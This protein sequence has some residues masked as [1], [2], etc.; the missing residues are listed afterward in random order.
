ME[1]HAE[2]HDVEDVQATLRQESAATLHG[3]AGVDV[4]RPERMRLK[5]GESIF[6][7]N[8]LKKLRD[9]LEGK[10]VI[11]IDQDGV[12]VPY[13]REDDEK[14]V[15]YPEAVDAVRELKALGYTLIYWTSGKHENSEIEEFLKRTEIDDLFSVVISRENFY[16]KRYEDK[17]TILCSIASTP[18]LSEEARAFLIKR[19]EKY[20]P[21]NPLDAMP[22]MPQCLVGECANIDDRFHYYEDMFEDFDITN[23]YPLFPVQTRGYKDSDYIDGVGTV[24]EDIPEKDTDRFF[25]PKWMAEIQEKFPV[26]RSNRDAAPSKSTQASVSAKTA[27]R[28]SKNTSRQAE[29]MPTFSLREM[30]N[31][32]LGLRTPVDMLTLVD[33]RQ[34]PKATILCA[35]PN[36][37][38]PEELIAKRAFFYNQGFYIQSVRNISV[39]GVTYSLSPQES[40]GFVVP[41]SSPDTGVDAIHAFGKVFLSGLSA[42]HGL[43]GADGTAVLEKFLLEEKSLPEENQQ[44][45]N[46]IRNILN[47]TDPIA[48]IRKPADTHQ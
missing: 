32:I 23:R 9:M 6:E 26:N 39:G 33:G 46:W 41:N 16:P 43:K 48:N 45:T 15:A 37:P 34:Y 8:T 3:G 10:R 20:K 25:G 14:M 44:F 42:D 35:I 17:P 5:D 19:V 47:G 12:L 30:Q 7:P 24:Y 18:W 36:D 4:T 1:V 29:A 21:G 27:M 13:H 11:L 31:L 28:H 22:K 38:N 2:K 40:I